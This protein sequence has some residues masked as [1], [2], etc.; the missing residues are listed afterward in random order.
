MKSRRVAIG[1]S[2]GRLRQTKTTLEASALAPTP[3]ILP[4]RSVRIGQVPLIPKPAWIT[5]SRN[6]AHPVLNIPRLSRVSDCLN[7]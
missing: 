7:A 1:A 5:A 2:A 4:L 3:I 6:V